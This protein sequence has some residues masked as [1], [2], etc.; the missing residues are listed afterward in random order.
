[1][2]GAWSGASNARTAVVA[3]EFEPS[4]VEQ[5]LLYRAFD[6]VCRRSLVTEQSSAMSHKKSRTKSEQAKAA[7]RRAA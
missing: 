2:D 5:E 3:R 1:M 7:G 4:R 6:L